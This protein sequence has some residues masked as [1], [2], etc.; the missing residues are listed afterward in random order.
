[1]YSAAGLAAGSFN[2]TS[3]CPWCSRSVESPYGWPISYHGISRR[4]FSL[5]Q[6][7]ILLTIP[8]MR[9]RRAHARFCYRDASSAA[10]RNVARTGQLCFPVAYGYCS[11]SSHSYTHGQTVFLFCLTPIKLLRSRLFVLVLPGSRSTTR[12]TLYIMSRLRAPV[13]GIM[14]QSGPPVR[15]G[16]FQ[17]RLQFHS[18]LILGN[19]MPWGKVN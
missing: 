1:M 11:T 6:C 14:G 2:L 15:F 17:S 9:R 16:E 13:W 4:T 7:P 12:R 3:S 5:R 19:V 18:F 10:S 8:E